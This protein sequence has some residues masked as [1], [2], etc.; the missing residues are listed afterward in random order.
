MG[1]DPCPPPVGEVG[2]EIRTVT[3]AAITVDGA[4]N[5]AVWPLVE[6][7]PL[8]SD[9]NF[10]DS[11]NEGWCR[12]VWQQ[13]DPPIVYGCCQIIDTQLEASVTTDDADNIWN[14][15]GIEYFLKANLNDELDLQTV[16]IFA[17]ILGTVRDE[18]YDVAGM[19]VLSDDVNLSAVALNEG[20]L[21]NNGGGDDA[22][23][24][25]EWSHE[26]PF[27]VT[28]NLEGRCDFN[29]N[30]ADQ[31][32]RLQWRAFSMLDESINDPSFWKT[33]RFACEPAMP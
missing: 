33:C 7:L 28:P 25:L 26:V 17:N 18:G 12:L 10:K 22:G 14:D 2:Y 27:A 23:Y 3:A 6:M 13:G 19:P 4:C 24:T 8:M 11:D 20:S 1:G 9:S 21:N 16:K 32:S 29:I 15:D 5:E 30:D 31:N